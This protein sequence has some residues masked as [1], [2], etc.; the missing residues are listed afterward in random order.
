MR[1]LLA[2][3]ILGLVTALVITALIA[4]I[5]KAPEAAFALVAGLSYLGGTLGLIWI[6]MWAID[7][8]RD[9]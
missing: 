8:L 5:I 3:T 7:E 6:T 2:Y 4:L 1:K 9:E